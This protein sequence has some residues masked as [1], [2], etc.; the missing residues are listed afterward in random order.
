MIEIKLVTEHKELEG[1]RQL[2]ED[3]LKKNL[4]PE[5]AESQ[6]FVTAEYS[7][8]FLE[9]LHRFSPSVIAKDGDLVVGFALVS[10][11]DIRNQH[12]LLGDLMNGIDKIIYQGKPLATARYVVVGQLCVAKG[13]RGMGLVDR[14]YQFFKT[15]LI[16]EYDYC[17][18]DIAANN[19]RSLKAHTKTG[20]QVVD[21]LIYG[22]LTWDIVLWDWTSKN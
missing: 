9:T 3:N 19:P 22:G 21:Q 13:Y 20:F 2:Q 15:S 12:A 16:S 10:T 6:G 7:L 11:K 14:M 1:I 4:S 8:E 17:L 18:T 5:E